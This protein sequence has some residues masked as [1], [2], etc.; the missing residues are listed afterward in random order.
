MIPQ[1]IAALLAPWCLVWVI[2][3]GCSR[4]APSVGDAAVESPQVEKLS[5]IKPSPPSQTEVPPIAPSSMAERYASLTRSHAADP[6]ELR[7]SLIAFY[8]GW[9]AAQGAEAIDHAMAHNRTLVRHAFAGWMGADPDA[10]RQWVLSQ[11]GSGRRQAG[12]AAGLLHALPATDHAARGEWAAQ[13]AGHSA[14]ARLVSE[15]AIG[16]GAAQPQAALDWLTN[17]P[18]GNARSNAIE[19]IF[20][21]WTEADPELASAHLTRMPTSGAKDLAI[22]SLAKAIHKD[23]PEAARLW[24]ETITDE[25]LRELTNGL[26]SKLAA[27]AGA[28]IPDL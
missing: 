15:V 24:A 17:L 7:R 11:S 16:W 27:S 19:T 6:A 23:D 2:A 25:S 26:L 5:G 3:I 20:Q 4:Q 13:F 12:L 18:D 28:A 21:R 14:G 9:G 8:Q 22:S 10:P 1:R